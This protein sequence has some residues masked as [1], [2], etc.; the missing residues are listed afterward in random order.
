ML[1][2]KKMYIVYL[3]KIIQYIKNIISYI[4]KQMYSIRIIE[5]EYQEYL[6]C[7]F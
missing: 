6:E 5:M 3:R 7:I 1:H 2:I 4:K